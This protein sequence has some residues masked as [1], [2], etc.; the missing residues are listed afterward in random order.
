MR[1]SLKFT[2]ILLLTLA[3]GSVLNAEEA[4]PAPKNKKAAPKVEAKEGKKAPKKE[5]AEKNPLPPKKEDGNKD[6]ADGKDEDQEGGKTEEKEVEAHKVE[7][8]PIVVTV[9]VSGILEGKKS[10]PLAM[11]LLRWADLLVVKSVPHG[12]EVKK[13]NVLVELDTRTLRKKIEELEM[14]MPLKHLDLEAARL[15]LETLQ[16]TT[17]IALEKARKAKM[18]AEED[19]AYFEDVSRP[20][21]EKDAEQDVKQVREYLAY[22]EEELNQLR[23]MY[24]ADDLTEETEEIILRR[25]ENTV[26]DYRWMLE[27]S[28]ERSRRTLNTLI[29]REHE[30]LQRSLLE[31]QLNWRANEKSLP[32]ALKKAEL[33][34]RAKTHEMVES[35]KSLEEHRR[36]LDALTVRAPHDGIVYLGMSQRGK[37]TTASTVERKLIPGGKLTMREI[38]MT[39]V[40][41]SNPELI[42]SISENQLADLEVGQ[43]AAVKL[44][45]D[46]EAEISGKV[47]SLSRVPYADNTFSGVIQLSK[48]DPD[49]VLFPGM[50]AEAEITV[51]KNPGALL[52]PSKAVKKEGEKE[53]V[54]LKG[55]AERVIE[56]GRASDGNVEVLKGLKV[57]EEIELS[58]K[59]AD[60]APEKADPKEEK[61]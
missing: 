17:P 46:P 20:M 8:G 38:F 11:D 56:T 24:E 60:D 3:V 21:R 16:K 39:V 43:A 27:Q 12:T 50:K 5:A 10:T 55:G 28:E 54:T 30:S 37:W 15:N 57:G 34:F 2:L 59:P 52:I 36:D 23:K 61:K 51:Y 22:A 53:I 1:L 58:A 7:K 31:T 49:A 35:E 44:T 48:G 32:D 13:G 29:P 42:L 47:A 14:G 33:E 45:S 25:A 40:D 26:N 9:K 18:Q 6:K 41:P 4:K 19:F